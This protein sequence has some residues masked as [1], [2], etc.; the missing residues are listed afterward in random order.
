MGKIKYY[1]LLFFIHNSLLAVE[2]IYDCQYQENNILDLHFVIEH[3]IIG[4]DTLINISCSV[5][6]QSIHCSG[7]QLNLNMLRNI[8][9]QD[10]LIKHMK[11]IKTIFK[12]NKILINDISNTFIINLKTS[13]ILWT[14]ENQTTKAFCK[15][16]Y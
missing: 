8:T 16:K 3:P 2:V 15:F 1:T 11:D 14:K 10:G 12:K 13:N 9:L 7:I 6:T 5:K 4:T